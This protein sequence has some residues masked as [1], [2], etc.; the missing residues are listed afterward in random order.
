M[1]TVIPQ[2]S[3]EKADYGIEQSP[4]KITRNYS[5]ANKEAI[6]VLAELINDGAIDITTQKSQEA[7]KVEKKRGLF[8]HDFW[9]MPHPLAN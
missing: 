1:D 3:I 5:E 9:T 8:S 7:I 4:L 2:G 6:G